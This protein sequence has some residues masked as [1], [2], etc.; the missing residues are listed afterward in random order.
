MEHLRDTYTKDEAAKRIGVSYS[1]L[2]NVLIK[3]GQLRTVKAGSRV[4]V[5]RAALEAF[6]QGDADRKTA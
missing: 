2:H 3:G 1:T 6:L 4:L 5:P